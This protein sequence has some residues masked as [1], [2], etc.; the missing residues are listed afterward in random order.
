MGQLVAVS[1]S[2]VVGLVVDGRWIPLGAV[3]ISRNGK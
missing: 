1:K 3:R 2:T